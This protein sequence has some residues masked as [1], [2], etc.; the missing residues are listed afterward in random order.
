MFSNLVD[1]IGDYNPGLWRE[2]KGKMTRGK[3]LLAVLV[4]IILQ[5]LLCLNFASKL[6]S[7]FYDDDSPIYNHYCTGTRNVYYTSQCIKTLLEQW[8][9]RWELWWFDLFSALS[10]VAIFVLLVGGTYI[11]VV[12]LMQEDKKG[13]LNFIRL[14]PLKAKDFFIGKMIGVP[15]L[16]LL[17][18]G[19]TIPLHFWAGLQSQISPHLILAFYFLIGAACTFFYSLALLFAIISKGFLMISA[20]ATTG[21]VFIILGVTNPYVH[22]SYSLI[23]LGVFNPGLFLNHLAKATLIPPEILGYPNKIE[24]ILWY[25]Q[26]IWSN[27]WGMFIT[28][29]LN[30]AWWTYIVQKGLQRIYNSPN[31]TL[32]SKIDSYWISSSFVFIWFGFVEQYNYTEGSLF[33]LFFFQFALTAIFFILIGSLS[34]HRQTLLDW[35]RYRHYNNR[36]LLKDLIVGEKSPAVVAI[37]INSLLVFSYLLI[38]LALFLPD[39]YKLSVFFSLF[40]QMTTICL[41][42][43]IV[44]LLLILPTKHRGTFALSS[45]FILTLAGLLTRVALYNGGMIQVFISPFALP[46]FTVIDFSSFV[47]T[48]ALE[49]LL[50]VAF[51][52]TM[53]KTLSQLGQSETK[54]LLR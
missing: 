50:F 12:D 35:S 31:S 10:L 25:G 15:S 53:Q 49:S 37:I 8:D 39:E 16:L 4:S 47:L 18:I 30:F 43:L 33:N 51:G 29:F 46:Y 44:Q 28:L 48:L 20:L 22:N 52:L 45:I 17:T 27:A 13:T 1:R 54:A 36:S 7:N 40:C 34:P 23:G 3:V 32:F 38:P 26:N 19:L 42:A 5:A 21:I 11:L 14:S 41:I 9:I 2:L 24:D 6:P